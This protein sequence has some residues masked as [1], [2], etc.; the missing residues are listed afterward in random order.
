MAALAGR[1]L[2]RH[3]DQVG[4]ASGRLPGTALRIGAGD[5][6]ITQRAIVDR[7]R[8]GGVLQ[9]DLGHQL[10]HAI[11]VDR[12][13]GRELA[14]R[15]FLGHAVGG[16]GRGEDEVTHPARHRA[17]DQRA[18]VGGVVPVVFERVLHRLRHDDRACEM[19]DRA[20]AEALERLRDQIRIPDIA[21]DQLRPLVDRPAEAGDEIVEHHHRPSAVEQRQHRMAADIAGAARN[22]DGKAGRRHAVSF[23]S[24]SD[25]T[26]PPS[27]CA[28]R[29]HGRGRGY[30]GPRR[31]R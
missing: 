20:D 27:A 23:P 29:Q 18:A 9:H 17:L 22:K 30:R 11:G 4:G 31:D 12:P 21:L 26:T 13:G 2:A 19:H 5:V 3:L 24:G 28:Y 7:V 16:G 15:A 8:G 6:E 1:R 10:G 14:H 25:R